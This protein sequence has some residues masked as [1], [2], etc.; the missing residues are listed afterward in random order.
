MLGSSGSPAPTA[1]LCLARNKLS[2]PAR[3]PPPARPCQ[4]NDIIFC[5]GGLLPHH[6]KYGLQR[7]NDEVAMWM[8]GERSGSWLSHIQGAAL[9]GCVTFKGQH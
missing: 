4:V 3:P 6:I 2:A 5:H 1:G 8:M 7:I 9:V